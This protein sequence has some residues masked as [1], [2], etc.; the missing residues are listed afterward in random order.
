MVY[1]YLIMFL[2]VFVI[3]VGILERK[4]RRR[5]KHAVEE[6]YE[7]ARTLECSEYD[8]FESAGRKWNFSQEKIKGDFKAYIVGN[9]LPHYVCKYV[10][11]TS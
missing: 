6:L 5:K 7:L 2:V 11:E 3:A 10:A 4:V 9:D 8:I 1:F